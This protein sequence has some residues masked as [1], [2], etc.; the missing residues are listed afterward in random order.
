MKSNI[1]RA[2]TKVLTAHVPLA[3][4]KKVDQVAHR[5]ERSRDRIMK[6][7]LSARLAQEEA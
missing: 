5:L 6:Q 7:A 1:T 3:L 2:P 4:A